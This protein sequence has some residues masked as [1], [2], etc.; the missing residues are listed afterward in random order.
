MLKWELKKIYK[1]KSFLVILIILLFNVLAMT[2]LNPEFNY[3]KEKKSHYN[4]VKNLK[5]ISDLKDNEDLDKEA[6]KLSKMAYDKLQKDRG[7][8]YK[9]TY[10]YN[11]FYFRISNALINIS[12]SIIIL[13]IFSNI[14]VKERLS[15]IDTILLSSKKKFNVLYSKLGLALII[16]ILIYITYI[17]IMA[18]ITAIQYGFPDMGYLQSYR[19]VENPVFLQGS[20]TINQYL[21]LT[22]LTITAL[23]VELSLFVSMC[24]FLSKDTVS[25]IVS[26]TVV[27]ILF[28][29]LAEAKFLLT[30]L[31]KIFKNINFIDTFKDPQMYIGTYKGSI[32]LL[33]NT[34]DLY[35][36]SYLILFV[37]IV[38]GVAA[39]IYI[40]KKLF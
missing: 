34:L 39:N 13:I 37:F 15:K 12:M 24:S 36:L 30:G 29:V 9:N 38:L 6:K 23:Y 27:L 22:A 17:I 31:L 1:N 33:N 4:N 8:E 21:I 35:Y 25:S 28:K 5:E 32:I 3:D 18:I 14:Y 20:L 40:F 10:F 7:E 11:I 16:P 26:A 19:I 2:F